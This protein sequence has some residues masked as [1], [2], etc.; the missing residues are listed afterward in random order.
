VGSQWKVNIPEQYKVGHEAHFA[1]VMQRYLQYL[2]AGSMPSW[3]IPSMLAKYYT[4]AKALE[5]ANKK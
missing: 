4:A 2:K 3:E 5:L 1:Q